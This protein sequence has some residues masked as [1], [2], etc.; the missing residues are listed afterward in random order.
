MGI[1]S[2]RSFGLLVKFLI[3]K[4]VAVGRIRVGFLPLVKSFGLCSFGILSAVLASLSRL[5]NGAVVHAEN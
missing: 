1:V 3:C 2:P 5:V 4:R